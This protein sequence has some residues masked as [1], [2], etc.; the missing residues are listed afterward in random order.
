LTSLPT[1]LVP[2]TEPPAVK[3]VSQLIE[4][5]E[6]HDDVKDVYTNAEFPGP[7]A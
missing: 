4:L 7:A 5:L 2:L 6:E 1:L 3:A